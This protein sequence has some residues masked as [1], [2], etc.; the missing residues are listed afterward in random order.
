M[1]RMKNFD[2][3]PPCDKIHPRKKNKVTIDNMKRLQ[4]QVLFLW[5][6]Q[7]EKKY[8]STRIFILIAP[9]LFKQFLPGDAEMF[10]RYRNI[11]T[12]KKKINKL[13]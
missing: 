2:P 10:L 8:L 7:M 13:P 6:H 12:K 4:F 9:F 1:L 5:P 11:C 3:P